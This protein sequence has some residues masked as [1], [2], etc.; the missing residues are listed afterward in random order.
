MKNIFQ[1]FILTLV[2][3]LGSCSKDA[4]SADII[5]SEQML[6]DKTWFLDY[7]ITS[8]GSSSVT[9]TY[10]GQSTYF[11]NFLKNRSTKDSDGLNGTYQIKNI[12]GKLQIQVNAITVGSTTV[13]YSYI[14][15]S[16]GAKDLVV[17]FIANSQTTKR[18]FSVR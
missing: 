9:K 8:T 7:S 2:L 1:I 14:V 13:E 17:S 15:E 4:S 18:Y 12:G 6:Q 5:L 10:V 16:V 3:T 11:I